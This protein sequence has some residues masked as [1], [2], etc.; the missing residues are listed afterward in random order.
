MRVDH[1]FDD[2]AIFQ[3]EFTDRRNNRHN[4]WIAVHDHGELSPRHMLE[5]KFQRFDAVKVRNIDEWDVG[6]YLRPE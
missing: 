2:I 3:V 1:H 4:R 6:L 5:K